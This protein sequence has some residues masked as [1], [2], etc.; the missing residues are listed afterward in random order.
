MAEPPTDASESAFLL[1]GLIILAY[2]WHYPRAPETNR[3]NSPGPGTMRT[4]RGK[5]R[6][7]RPLLSTASAAIIEV[8]S[9]DLDLASIQATK[10]SF[11]VP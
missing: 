3:A 9:L 4:R 10:S 6:C 1:V 11:D 7:V 5:G 2:N 8:Q